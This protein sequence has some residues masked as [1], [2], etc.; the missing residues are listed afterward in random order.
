MIRVDAVETPL[1]FAT[2][3]VNSHVSVSGLAP[4]AAASIAATAAPRWYAAHSTW[5]ACRL[6]IERSAYVAA[7]RRL[8]IFVARGEVDIDTGSRQ[9]TLQRGHVASKSPDTLVLQLDATAQENE[10]VILSV[11]LPDSGEHK[12][13]HEPGRVTRFLDPAINAFT[14]AA[15]YGLA[16]APLPQ[17]AGALD[18]LYSAAANI[19]RT[20]LRAPEPGDRRAPYEAAIHYISL[21]ASD[22]G[23]SVAE[24]VSVTGVPTRTLQ[25]AFHTNGD[26]IVRAV[27]R[28][29]VL[30]AHGIWTRNPDQAH[31]AVAKQAGFSSV[32]RLRMALQE[33]D[34][35]TARLMPRAR[36]PVVPEVA[37]ATTAGD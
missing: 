10:L 19:G 11:E 29:R 21:H 28:A 34:E 17:T 22:P 12:H 31:E 2:T 1:E 9:Y 25:L 6:R 14:Y 37:Q 15:A 26:T 30:V 8:F 18:V 27:R 35:V 33:F 23:L 20:L 5:P 4:G 16:R 24:I 7:Q 3:L 36:K 32:R 13:E